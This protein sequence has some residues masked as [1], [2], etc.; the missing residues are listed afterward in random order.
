MTPVNDPDYVDWQV[1]YSL[2]ENEKFKEY[3][4]GV[5]KCSDDDFSKFYQIE[6]D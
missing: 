1:M 2:Y 6:E 5:H 3:L 4:V